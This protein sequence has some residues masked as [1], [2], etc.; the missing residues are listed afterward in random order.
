MH[1]TLQPALVRT[2]R[3]IR[4]EALSIFYHINIFTTHLHRCDFGFFI[5]YTRQI[6]SANRNHIQSV[7]II[8]KDKWT[9]GDGIHDFLR[10]RVTSKGADQMNVAFSIREWNQE[11]Y[12]AMSSLDKVQECLKPGSVSDHMIDNLDAVGDILLIASRLYK[13]GKTS[14]RHIR[15]TWS[16]NI[17]G[18]FECDYN[19][20]N[21]VSDDGYR[22]APASF[23]SFC[24]SKF[25]RVHRKSALA[26]G[27]TDYGAASKTTAHDVARWEAANPGCY[28]FG[29]SINSP[30]SPSDS[31]V[32][33]GGIFASEN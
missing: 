4:K 5:D 2:S 25:Q 18:W 3:Q 12:E 9:C 21:N 20:K 10:W 33:F 19:C 23:R 29:P 14:E 13:E 15:K 30:E 11:H 28:D 16:E 6:G 1:F 26:S 17:Y 32:I 27:C 22:H 24:T 31:E 7:S 8:L